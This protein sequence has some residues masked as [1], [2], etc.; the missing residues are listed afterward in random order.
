MSTR[1]AA[2]TRSSRRYELNE[3][4]LHRLAAIVRG[5]DTSRLDLT[6][7]SSGLFAI[8]PG[9][10]ATYPD[11]HE[12]LRRGMVVYDPLYV[13]CQTDGSEAHNWPPVS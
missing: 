2:S 4:A 7:E 3:P 9:L 1:N 10:A 13:W 8:S 5:G 12:M 11:D 6:P